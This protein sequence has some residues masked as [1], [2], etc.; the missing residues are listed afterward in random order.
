MDCGLNCEV[1]QGREWSK[2]QPGKNRSLCSESRWNITL[3]GKMA[4]DYF[5]RC[6][7]MWTKLIQRHK[8]Q[9]CPQS[10]CKLYQPYHIPYIFNPRSCLFLSHSL[11]HS[12]LISF[13]FLFAQFNK[14]GVTNKNRKPLQLRK[15]DLMNCEEQ[16]HAT[17]LTGA[18]TTKVKWNN[19]S[20]PFSV[21]FLICTT[22]LH[23]D[24]L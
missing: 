11:Y 21:A 16:S 20:D 17:S 4:V 12:L 5:P 1:K 13:F 6:S 24:H 22:N 10:M 15:R 18:R 9:F 2:C 8:I 3:L 7:M 23:I 19:L 14:L